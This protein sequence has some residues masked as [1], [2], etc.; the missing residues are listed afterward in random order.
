[1]AKI[2]ITVVTGAAEQ[3]LQDMQNQIEL[4]VER[5]M[6]AIALE[7][8]AKAKASIM[9][10]PK[11]GRIYKKYNPKR[12]H[13]ASAP[14]EAPANDLGFLVGSIRAEPTPGEPF[15][16]TLAAKADYAIHLE[17]GTRNMAA[18]PFLKPAGDAMKGR[19]E[20]ILSAFLRKVQP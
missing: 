11:T 12:T 8:E 4:Q 19:G 5:A 7:A 10:G 9:R 18:R 14:G 20:E 2:D 3:D 13:Q 16:V 17:Y 6:M 1:M 15:K